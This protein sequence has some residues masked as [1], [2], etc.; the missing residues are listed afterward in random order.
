VEEALTLG[1]WD[2]AAIRHLAA[3]SDLTHARS[4]I[5]ELG[6]LSCFERPLPAMKDYDELLAQEVA[7]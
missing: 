2:A 3:A 7:R 6:K 1:C 5:I 4:T